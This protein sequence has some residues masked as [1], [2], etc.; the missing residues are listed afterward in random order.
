VGDLR[1]DLPGVGRQEPSASVG[2]MPLPWRSISS[3]PVSRCN[4]A[5]CWLIAEGV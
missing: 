1:L 2:R 4:A 3:V 5:T